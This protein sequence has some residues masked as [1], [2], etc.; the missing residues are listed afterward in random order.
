MSR[1]ICTL[2]DHLSHNSLLAKETNVH[3]QVDFFARPVFKLNVIWSLAIR[4]YQDV[5]YS[6]QILQRARNGVESTSGHCSDHVSNERGDE[7]D[8]RLS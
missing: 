3:N 8:N 7:E 6:F 2:N 4:S 5:T 1:K